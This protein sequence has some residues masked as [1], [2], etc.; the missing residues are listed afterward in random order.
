MTRRQFL[1]ASAGALAAPLLTTA[2]A[3]A[4]APLYASDVLDHAPK[5]LGVP[6]IY[7]GNNPKVGLDCSSYVS[8]V[9]RIPR[10]STD[11]IHNYSYKIDKSE[12]MPGDA[13]NLPFVGRRSHIRLFAG[14]ADLDKTVAWMYECARSRG[15]VYRVVGYN[16]EY[17]PIRRSNF[18][19][20][21]PQ[22]PVELP[23]EYDVS[24]GR[25]FSQYGSRDGKSGFGVL[26]EGGV[27]F[28][29]EF[30][31]LGGV[32]EL[33]LPLSHRFD[34]W[35]TPVQLLEKGVLHWRS[36]SK[37]ADVGPPPNVPHLV[38]PV[39]ALTPARSPYLPKI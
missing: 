3:S 31:R 34:S 37:R 9:W 36:E 15:T 32:K 25:F 14:W 21:V 39:D 33:G 1:I 17:T 38:A 12:L 22:P 20:D 7:G 8:L 4:A 28:W 27:N 18:V 11:T 26:N 13:L 29:D 24:N 10:Q 6:Y 35:A 5:Y 30:K 23:V 16:D 19:A 2:G